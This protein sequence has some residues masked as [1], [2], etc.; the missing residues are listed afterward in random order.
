MYLGHLPSSEPDSPSEAESLSATVEAAHH[1]LL[2]KALDDGR[3][4]PSST[5]FTSNLVVWHWRL[6]ID[7]A[8]R[9]RC[10]GILFIDQMKFIDFFY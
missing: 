9:P 6:R 1:E 5:L 10:F 2:N 8:I 3:Y 4:G 7:H